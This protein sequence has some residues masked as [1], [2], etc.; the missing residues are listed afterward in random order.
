M[1]NENHTEIVERVKQNKKLFQSF[2][3][4]KLQ[5]LYD[6]FE[7]KEDSHIFDLIPFLLHV[8]QPEFPG[9]IKTENMPSGIYDY[10]PSTPTMNYIRARHP[11]VALPRD[12]TKPFIQ[13]FALM[14]SGGT[15][16]FN[17][18]SDF[19]FWVCADTS[20]YSPEA[21]RNFRAKCKLIEKYYAEHYNKEVHFFLNDITDVRNNIFDD[22]DE[23]GLSGISLGY[24]LKEEFFRS[25]IVIHGK[26]PFW[27]VVPPNCPDD[28]YTQWLNIMKKNGFERDY[29]DL[30][31]L[32]SAR[33]NDFL[34]AALFQ[35]LKSLGNPFKSLIKLGLLERYINDID[36]NPY[37]SNQIKR[38]V[39]AGNIT[40]SNTDAYIVMFN[41]VYDYYNSIRADKTASSIMKTCFYLKI[42]PMVSLY[43]DRLQ[44]DRIPERS[45][46]MNTLVKE[47]GW[48]Q[49]TVERIDDF[50]NWDIEETS[51]LMVSIKKYILQ[52]YKNILGNL[53]TGDTSTR[54]HQDTLKG[55]S[56][57]IYS[58]F[59]PEKHKVDNTL[60][61]KAFQPEKLL[62]MEFVKDKDGK[63]FWILGKTKITGSGSYRSIMYKTGDLLSLVVWVSL[64]GLFQ[65]DYTRLNIQ[66]GYF[67]INHSFIQNLLT[68]LSTSFSIKNI[69]LHNRYFLQEPFPMMSHVIINFYSKQKPGIDNIFFL[70]HNSWGET[71]FEELHNE[72]DLAGLITNIVN[73]GLKTGNDY[74]SYNR[75]TASDPFA[76]TREFRRLKTL[77]RDIYTFFVNEQH[78]AKKRYI[79]MIGGMYYVFSNKKDENSVTVGYKPCESEIKLL[80]SIAYNRGIKTRIKIDDSVPELNYL[81]TIIENDIENV[82]Q[83]YYQVG[84]KYCYYFVSD[85]RGSLI[86]YRKN[87]HFHSEYLGRLYNFAEGVVQKV[88]ENNPN[89]ILARVETRIKLY[90]M[91]R[92]IHHNVSIE[93]INPEMETAVFKT[94][95]SLVPFKLSLHLLENGDFGYRFTLPDGGYTDIFD[96][97]DVVDVTKEIK[98]LMDS[99]KGYIYYL[100]DINLLYAE[101]PMYKQFTSISFSEKNRFELMIEKGLQNLN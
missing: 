45:R 57:K 50:E 22:E 4:T 7:K 38:D 29:I 71:R 97:S 33:K 56:R 43:S 24:L 31:N 39:Q 35:I 96:R 37:I 51:K 53:E 11:S 23:E 86:F 64:H 101:L 59:A 72:S 21:I 92:D 82:V 75:I 48:T 36:R 19:D 99:V 77:F 5:H 49:G 87:A 83:L 90:E 80:Y 25:S 61:I 55:I 98:V 18:Q 70:Y 6:S 34:I 73:G 3:S 58:H 95:K 69:N 14:G 60:N 15:I 13:M 54:L 88:I 12:N 76:S 46:I 42:D 94:R 79:T 20:E 16:A 91:K 8:N 62:S 26:I 40:T 32:Y 10:K 67:S 44:Q 28:I 89:S 47:W 17:K 81:R 30:G 85:E 84:T 41:H 1:T 68:E 27:W 66:S 78:T 65:K 74:D 100:T 52:G 93:E 63:E 2:N 9:Y